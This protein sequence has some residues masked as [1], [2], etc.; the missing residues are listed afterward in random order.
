M[1][2]RRRV[3][4]ID[5]RD[6]VQISHPVRSR[7]SVNPQLNKVRFFSVS[8]SVYQYLLVVFVWTT[9]VKVNVFLFYILTTTL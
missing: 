5:V 3:A 9:Y 8:N 1:F 2:R 6:L 7:T 4:V